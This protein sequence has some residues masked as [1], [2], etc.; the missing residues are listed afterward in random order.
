VRCCPNSGADAFLDLDVANDLARFTLL[1]AAT[2]TSAY[3][4]HRT[5]IDRMLNKSTRALPGPSEA[6]VRTSVCGL[7]LDHRARQLATQLAWSLRGPAATHAVRRE[8]AM[9]QKQY[10]QDVS[11]RPKTA[12]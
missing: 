7:K 8:L 2:A 3:R 4:K 5:F 10:A 11:R 9:A 12:Y 6:N 1:D